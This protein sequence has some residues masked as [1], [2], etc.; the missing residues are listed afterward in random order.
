MHTKLHIWSLSS[1][2]QVAMLDYDALVLKS[3]DAM[4]DECG[5]AEFCSVPDHVTPKQPGMRIFNGGLM[6]LRPNQATWKTLVGHAESEA[7]SGFGRRWS[8]QG[9]LNIAFPSWKELPQSYNIPYYNVRGW[10]S[11]NDRAAS[12][13]NITVANGFFYHDKLRSMPRG[14]VRWVAEG[15]SVPGKPLEWALTYEP[16]ECLGYSARYFEQCSRPVCYELRE[17]G[18]PCLCNLEVDSNHVDGHGRLSR[19]DSNTGTRSA[20]PLLP[21]VQLVG[22]HS[23]GDSVLRGGTAVVL[24]NRTV[25]D[26]A[27]RDTGRVRVRIREPSSEAGR[28]W[29]LK[30]SNLRVLP[31]ADADTSE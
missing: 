1:C 10:G 28:V 16:S 4:F 5:A 17:L 11:S 8:E 9:F 15:A 29:L 25:I 20:T 12:V 2:A 13:A 6:V 23:R 30:P 18:S 26:A 21:V 31:R 27:G 3:M 14:L 19:K 24:S 7:E 22:L